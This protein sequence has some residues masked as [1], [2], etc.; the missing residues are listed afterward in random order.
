[1]IMPPSPFRYFRDPYH[2]S[3]YENKGE[4]CPFCGLICVGYG[5]GFYGLDTD[6]YDF[7]CEVCL[8]E[9]RLTEKGFTTNDGGDLR[10][11]I[12]L[13]FPELPETELEALIRTRTTELEQ[14]TPQVE[15]WQG[16]TWPSHCGD[17]CCFLKEAGQLD[18]QRLAPNSNGRQ[19]FEDHMEERQEGVWETIRPDAPV[20]NSAAYSVGVYLFQCLEC[21]QYIIQWDCD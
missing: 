4:R 19:F 16:L 21:S 9:G 11:G 15:T 18:M 14:H 10:P 1:M 20:D 5:G 8:L 17:F 3:S 6:G 13:R 2:F 12:H 7:I